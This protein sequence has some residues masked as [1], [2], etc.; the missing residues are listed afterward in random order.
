VVVGRRM[1]MVWGRMMMMTM[2]TTIATRSRVMTLLW[3]VQV[4]LKTL[5]A[6][7]ARS[8]TALAAT[9]FNTNG[10]AYLLQVP[11]SHDSLFTMSPLGGSHH[12]TSLPL[13][14]VRLWP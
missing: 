2:T 7:E 6:L 13:Y 12:L 9:I 10:R 8:L 11:L 5:N 14:L 4:H 3:C 1:M